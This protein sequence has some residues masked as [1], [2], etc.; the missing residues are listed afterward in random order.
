MYICI[1][2]IWFATKETNV[3]MFMCVDNFVQDVFGP[4]E[5]AERK[6]LKFSNAFLLSMLHTAAVCL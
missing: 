2:V 1:S 6:G 4:C 5:T 3:R